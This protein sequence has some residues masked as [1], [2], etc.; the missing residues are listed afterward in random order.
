[1]RRALFVVLVCLAWL[2]M[3]AGCA[4]TKTGLQFQPQTIGVDGWVPRAER[5]V[6]ILDDSSS[7]IGP[8]D[9]EKKYKIATRL[10]RSLSQTIPAL[11]YSAGLRSFGQG[12]C[13]PREE[14][15]LL[16][17]MKVYSAGDFGTT[18]DRFQCANRNSP[19]D[20]A[21]TAA[22]EDLAA[23]S[24]EV[25]IIAISDGLHMGQTE[26]D[27]AG[28]LVEQF[29]DRL[30]IY[31][32]QV[33]DDP[34]GE[35]MLAAVAEVTECGAR[36]S[37]ADLTSGAAMA[38]FVQDAL[39]YPDSD[40]DGVPDHLDK[41]PNTPKGVEVDADGCP[42]DTDGDG[43]PDYQD[44][45]PNTPAGVKV[46]ASGCP[47]DTDGDG[48]PDYQDECPDTPRGV[49]VDE[50]G[51][52]LDT[53]GDGVLDYLD[54][55][56]DTPKG[57]PVD[58]E[59]CPPEGLEYVDGEWVIR[60]RLLFET[61]KWELKEDVLPLLDRT[62]DYLQKNTEWIVE[63]QGH[64]DSSGRLEWNMELSQNRAD[65]VRDYLVSQGVDASRITTT[66]HGP[67][68]PM[69]SNETPEGRAQNRRVDFVP[70]NG[71]RVE[72]ARHPCRAL[73]F[74][75]LL[76]RRR[77]ASALPPEGSGRPDGRWPAGSR[78]PVPCAPGRSGSAAS[79]PA[80]AVGAWHG[81]H[82]SRP[83]RSRRIPGL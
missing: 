13:L 23:A 55:C 75:S 46:D 16:T 9:H 37:A 68:E 15:T 44:K 8:V 1:M 50:K 48:V 61:N 67:N 36:H 14:T 2:A 30:C 66:A 4:S 17:G 69:E 51:C 34:R 79:R 70:A 12:N 20:T 83:P 53:D 40:G 5:F 28:A 35:K 26:L 32:I 81:G 62:V 43:V 63:I 29:G 22:G 25:A 47:L 31:T 60:G 71:K 27:A 11:D 21:L 19:L 78:A 72:R 57:V 10:A 42:V 39:L 33:G 3:V 74:W 24:G 65:S 18:L 76:S 64:T 52:P 59:G 77:T 82:A 7:M 56:P 80:Q 49:K 73:F 45:C 38:Q 41:C 54:K 58:D 6:V